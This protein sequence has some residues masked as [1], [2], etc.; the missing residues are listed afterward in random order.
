MLAD[1]HFPSHETMFT[2]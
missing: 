1:G 2:W